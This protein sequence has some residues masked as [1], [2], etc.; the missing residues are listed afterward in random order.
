MYDNLTRKEK[1]DL[2]SS[3]IFFDFV[4]NEF[5]KL[6]KEIYDL[7]N[8]HHIDANNDIIGI[9]YY[10][11]Q[12]EEKQLYARSYVL[13][14]TARVKFTKELKVKEDK[15]IDHTKLKYNFTSKNVFLYK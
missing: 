11:K 13:T 15:T 1:E 8:L 4:N 14:K 3:K 10:H 9:I 2:A 6:T 12:K 7:K 5:L